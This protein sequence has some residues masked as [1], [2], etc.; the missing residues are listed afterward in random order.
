MTEH[1][2]NMH[3]RKKGKGTFWMIGGMLLIAAAF[4]LTVFNIYDGIRAEREAQGILE[5]LT[6]EMARQGALGAAGEQDGAAGNSEGIS[7]GIFGESGA[8]GSQADYELFP[9]KEMPVIQVDGIWYVGVLEIPALDL[10]LP[11]TEEW[12]YGNLRN[13]LCRYSGSL[14]RND[15]VIAGHNYRRF[16]RDLRHLSPGAEIYFTDAAGNR[17]TYQAAWTEVLESDEG[18]VMTEPSDEWDL[19]LFTCTYGGRQRFA[20]RCV[21]MDSSPADMQH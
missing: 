21:K 18:E 5:A 6:G 11:V 15:L 4:L 20:V 19:T 7:G 10:I 12:S 13:A 1:N 14:Y 9:D 16:F 2:R 3:R 8:D 17:F